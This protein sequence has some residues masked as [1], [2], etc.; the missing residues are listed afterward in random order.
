MAAIIILLFKIHLSVLWWLNEHININHQEI[1]K[2]KI[3]IYKYLI[4]KNI[5]ACFYLILGK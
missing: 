1:K 2:H 4:S 3:G 5:F